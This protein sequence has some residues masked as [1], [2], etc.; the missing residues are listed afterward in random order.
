[1]Y[2][3]T[4]FFFIY[5]SI[6]NVV[7]VCECI[8]HQGIFSHPQLLY[9]PLHIMS[10]IFPTFL[11]VPCAYKLKFFSCFY[12]L[13]SKLYVFFC[14]ISY[15]YIRWTWG[16]EILIIIVFIRVRKF[17]FSFSSFLP[18]VAVSFGNETFKL[19][20]FLLKPRLLCTIGSEEFVILD[21]ILVFLGSFT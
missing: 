4:F 21:N 6:L 15:T 14:Y 17:W 11:H 2:K 1:M 13:L 8:Q 18:D 19:R 5:I 16:K 10:E 12:F 3:H 7:Y 9:V 20:N